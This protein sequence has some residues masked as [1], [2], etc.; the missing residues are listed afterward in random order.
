[1]NLQTPNPSEEIS[2]SPSNGFNFG[3]RDAFPGVLEPQAQGV[4]LSPHPIAYPGQEIKDSRNHQ[5][6]ASYSDRALWKIW[7]SDR[8][9]GQSGETSG[10][11]DWQIQSL[12]YGI[13]SGNVIHRPSFWSLWC[14]SGIGCCLNK[15]KTA[16]KMDGD[17]Q[18]ATRM[19]TPVSLWKM[20][21]IWLTLSGIWIMSWNPIGIHNILSWFEIWMGR[22]WKNDQI[23][24]DEIQRAVRKPHISR[25]FRINQYFSL[26]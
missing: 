20:N 14:S 23:F 13:N 19:A 24:W 6:A 4:K 10:K 21:T 7:W 15:G 3:P 1:L 26:R 8:Q 25:I 9:R 17:D 16:G 22:D 5:E 2:V 11:E 12:N 18:E